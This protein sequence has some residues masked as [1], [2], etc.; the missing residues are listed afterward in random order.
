MSL[1]FNTFNI[2]GSNSGGGG[3]AADASF[4]PLGTIF[5]VKADGT[6]D[7]TTLNDAI[8]YLDGK[9][10][11]GIVTINLDEGTHTLTKNI[12]LTRSINIPKI[13]ISGQSGGGTIVE[14][15]ATLTGAMVTFYWAIHF[16]FAY[17]NFEKVAGGLTSNGFDISRGTN[18]S[19]NSCSFENFDKCLV[20]TDTGSSVVY[21]AMSF[22]NFTTALSVEGGLVASR[23]NTAF[24]F[25][26][27]T[28]SGTAFSVSYGGQIHAGA[29]NSMAYTKIATH[30]SQT[31]GSANNNGWITGV[32]V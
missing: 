20:V 11:N 14:V 8:D 17:I 32:S 5:T 1:N 23:S 22:T 10:S 7:F 9:W 21:G 19:L 13:T 31:V 16:H 6:G 30:A 4:I 2:G 18:V 15:P 3:G 29:N 25:T 27:P 24:T 12:S 26:N 28:S